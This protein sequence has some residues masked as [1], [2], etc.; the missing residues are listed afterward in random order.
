MP[1]IPDIPQ[2]PEDI[3]SIEESPPPGPLPE[4]SPGFPWGGVVTTLGLI[5]VIVFAVQNTESVAVQFLWIQGQFPLSM[6]ILVTALATTVLTVLGGAVYRRARRRR[7]AER[8]EL[9]LRR[10]QS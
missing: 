2:V 4:P 5:L 1:D 8:Q 10:E 6:V 9:R 3:P 7:R